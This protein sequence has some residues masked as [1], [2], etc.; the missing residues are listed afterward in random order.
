V[1]Y[2]PPKDHKDYLHRSGRTA[3]AGATGTVLSLVEEGQGREVARIHASASISA[4]H[5]R[6]TGGHPA[7]RAMAESGSPIALLT[8]PP[9]ISRPTGNAR[10]VRNGPRRPTRTA[11]AGPVRR[12]GTQSG[13]Q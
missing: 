12:A 13:G 11:S 6:V 3:R 7:V 8:A 2:D 5:A 9:K 1:H 10:P 4:E